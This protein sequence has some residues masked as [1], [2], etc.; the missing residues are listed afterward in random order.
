M[1]TWEDAARIAL[2]LPDTTEGTSYGSMAWKVKDKKFA[3]KRPLR[4]SD[5]E[6]LGGSASTGAV[7]AVRVPDVGVKE[8]LLATDPDVYFTTPHFDGYP[9]ILVQLERIPVSELKELLVEAWLDRAPKR[10]AE[11]YLGEVP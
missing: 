2:G 4:R 8:S 7:L 6:A 3:W 9:I 11:E 10:V 5:Q 1:A